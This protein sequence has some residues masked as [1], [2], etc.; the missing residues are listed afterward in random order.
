MLL[1]ELGPQVILCRVTGLA[2]L[3]RQPASLAVLQ[4]VCVAR[5]F[6]WVLGE[7]TQSRLCGCAVPVLGPSPFPLLC[8]SLQ[9]I[10]NS[11]EFT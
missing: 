2:Q 8:S 10:T 9:V 4:H 3:C 11:S 1:K 6:E 7:G 5:V